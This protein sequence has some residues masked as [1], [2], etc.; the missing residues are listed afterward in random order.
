M[1]CVP[2]AR[3]ARLPP[4]SFSPFPRH[5]VMH[6]HLQPD[7]GRHVSS[8]ALW[9]CQ[10]ARLHNDSK[11]EYEASSARCD[12]PGQRDFADMKRESHSFSAMTQFAQESF[13]M[14]GANTSLNGAAV[15]EDFFKTLASPTRVGARNQR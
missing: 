2:W 15:D 9:R 6:R 5:R 7:D 3:I 12:H 8:S 13:K 4:F 1:G 14:N 10:T 11:S